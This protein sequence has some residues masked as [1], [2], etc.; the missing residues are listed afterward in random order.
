MV[1]IVTNHP[2]HI[3]DEMGRI[4]PSALIPFCDIGGDMS[5]VGTQLAHFSLPVCTGFTR[6]ILND[7]L[8]YQVNVSQF[9]GRV[10]RSQLYEKGISFVVDNN[11]DRQ[12]SD[13]KAARKEENGKPFNLG[14]QSKLYKS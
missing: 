9:Q 5:V 13:L 2:V 8:C 10:E 7:R 12:Y 11:E 1:D 3:I 4:S 6:T 14:R